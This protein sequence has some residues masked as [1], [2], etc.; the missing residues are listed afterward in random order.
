MVEAVAAEEVA[1]HELGGLVEG[2]VAYEADEV[3]V[4]GGDVLEEVQVG[5]LLGD[6][7]A[8]VLRV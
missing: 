8:S 5:R 2:R 6:G 3:A 7:G 4:G 1:A